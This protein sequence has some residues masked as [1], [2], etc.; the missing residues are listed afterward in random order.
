MTTTLVA[1]KDEASQGAQLGQRKT[2][3]FADTNVGF[4]S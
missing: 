1:L 4:E 3:W 2:D